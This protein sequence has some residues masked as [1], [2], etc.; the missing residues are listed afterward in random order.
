MPFITSESD[1]LTIRPWPLHDA[2]C[3]KHFVRSDSFRRSYNKFIAEGWAF[4]DVFGDSPASVSYLRAHGNWYQ[5][6]GGGDGNAWD[7]KY[8]SGDDFWPNPG[9]TIILQ[10]A[11]SFLLGDSPLTE[12]TDEHWHAGLVLLALFGSDEAKFTVGLAC[13]IDI[14]IAQVKAAT[15]IKHLLFWTGN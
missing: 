13:R 6:P 2:Y 7:D 4:F 14:L 9:D 15:C 11:W 5:K 8:D 1:Y 12:E 10:R 3:N